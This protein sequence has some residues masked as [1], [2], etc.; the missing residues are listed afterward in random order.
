MAD[1][2]I[3]TDSGARYAVAAAQLNPLRAL[4][5]AMIQSP[6]ITTSDLQQF[7]DDHLLDS[8]K[9]VAAVL[10]KLQRLGLISSEE[11]PIEL[12]QADAIGGLEQYL[13][14]I[15]SE[16]RALLADRNGFVMASHGFKN[17][18]AREL[19]AAGTDMT[20]M[21]ERIS[22]EMEQDEN[23]EQEIWE[24]S[25]NRKG[26]KITFMRLYIG[27]LPFLVVIGGQLDTKPNV[28]LQL[29]AILIHRYIS[30]A[31]KN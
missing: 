8:R 23:A 19:A 13:G 29:M 21:G 27:P 20:P 3:P 11:S 14:Q 10:Y 31:D 2:L 4:L 22:G 17:E 9:A 15:S 30:M 5:Y 16:G 7:I 12:P 1:Y 28:F 25:V 18:V 26:D 6:S 24:L